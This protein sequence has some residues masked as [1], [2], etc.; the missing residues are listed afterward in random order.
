MLFMYQNKYIK[1][2]MNG[3]NFVLI[4]IVRNVYNWLFHGIVGNSVCRTWDS[5]TLAFPCA[6]NSR[7][8]HEGLRL[9][10][11]SGWNHLE[12]KGN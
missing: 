3:R 10:F 5:C 7:R 12:G 9:S 4:G 11:H 8:A 6:V 1:M 2:N